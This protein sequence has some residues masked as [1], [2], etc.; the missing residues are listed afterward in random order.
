MNYHCHHSKE[1]RRNS[2]RTDQV[3]TT[4]MTRWDK[5]ILARRRLAVVTE[6]PS[7]GNLAQ[8]EIEVIELNSDK[9]TASK[10]VAKETEEELD[11]DEF[12]VEQEVNIND[13]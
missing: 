6:I 12:I 9:N 1:Y 7:G 13:F 5:Q 3:Y 10:P 11:I 4:L 8:K 2:I